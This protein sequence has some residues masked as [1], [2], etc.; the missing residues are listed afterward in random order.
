MKVIRVPRVV[1]RIRYK[2][3]CSIFCM[4][5]FLYVYVFMYVYMYFV[6]M[7]GQIN[8]K[9]VINVKEKYI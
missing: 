7:Y 6:P 8:I 3:K 2:N 1:R 5:V 9:K 4:R